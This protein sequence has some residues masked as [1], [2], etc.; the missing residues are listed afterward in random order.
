M[1]I[2]IAMA[3][4]NGAKFISEQLESFIR[5]IRLPDEL[6]VTD[7]G[8]SDATLNI[9]EGFGRRASFP[10][11]IYRNA[12]NLG[13]A[14]NFERAVSLC[15]GDLIFLSDQDDVW[16]PQKLERTEEYFRAHPETQVVIHDALLADE[17][18]NSFGHTQRKNIAKTANPNT[19]FFN[20]CCSA[21]RKSWHLLALPLPPGFA[22]DDWINGLAIEVGCAHQLDDILLAYRRHDRSSS[23]WFVSKPRGVTALRGLIGGLS[24]GRPGW[25][26]HIKLLQ[27]AVSRLSERH[28]IAA[29]QGWK[30]A[31]DRIHCHITA[32]ERR[33]EICSRPRHRR[34]PKVLQFWLAGGYERAAGVKSA[35]KDLIRP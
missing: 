9:L 25:T 24:D 14:R 6:V 7:D 22:H 15:S 35:I 29:A 3:T 2:S 28:D 31:T 10:V 4:Y 11:K 17:R 33:I 8:S 18:L 1:K 34:V 16:F 20:G 23:D 12:E 32:L 27:H 30:S 19:N 5:Q 26:R 13:Y 21:H